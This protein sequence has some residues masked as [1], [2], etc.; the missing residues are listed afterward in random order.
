MPQEKDESIE[1]EFNKLLE[2]SSYISHQLDFNYVNG[3]SVSLGETLEWVIK[4][5]TQS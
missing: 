4:L 5:V 3:R 2:A 1:R